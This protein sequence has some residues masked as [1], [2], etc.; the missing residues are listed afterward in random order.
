MADLDR[1]TFLATSALMAGSASLLGSFGGRAFAQSPAT[2][3][4][5]APR[6]RALRIAHLTD[7]HVQPE[8]GAD[9]GMAACLAR[10]EA[11]D[12][13]PDL[14]LFGGD[15]VMDVFE[16]K[17]PRA[18]ELG[19]LFTTTCK[20]HCTIP[21]RHAI[22]NHDIFGWT[23]ADGAEATPRHG[24]EY[25]LDLF[26]MAKR[27]YSF[28]QG[29]W[30]FVVLDSVQPSAD[31][32]VAFCDDEQTAWLEADL[33][34]R[35]AGS[36]VVVLTHIPILS[37]TS[38]TYGKHRARET[39]GQ[40]TVISA[41]SMHTDGHSLHNLFKAAGVKLCLSGHQHLLDRCSTD[42]VTYIC[43]GA[44]SGAWW[45]GACQGC[46]EGFG[47]IDLYADGSF[48]HSYLTYGWSARA[49]LLERARELVSG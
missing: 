18:V 10:V 35:P 15:S 41:G 42:G 44:V 4:I 19:G 33:K 25:A 21:M 37:L 7:I 32:Y 26:G 23:K 6:A 34:G 29:G 17:R 11:L 9:A 2:A 47:L 12:P 14:I 39:I 30:H 28:D 22:G 27:Y 46:P 3:P 40:D 20:N 45:K 24:K 5:A 43:D 36:P 38:I 13:R 48:D 1:R 16:V 8:R 49:S 31:G